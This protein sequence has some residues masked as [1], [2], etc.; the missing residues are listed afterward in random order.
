MGDIPSS[1]LT[2]TGRRILLSRGGEVGA[3][4]VRWCLF[5]RLVENIIAVMVVVVMTMS[6]SR[7]HE[8]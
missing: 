5:Q 1:L 3:C 6:D 8:V 4:V 2:P 7:D